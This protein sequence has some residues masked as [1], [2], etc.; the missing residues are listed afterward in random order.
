MA[1]DVE[2]LKKNKAGKTRETSDKEVPGSGYYEHPNGTSL[3][4]IED[5]LFG[6][7]QAEAAVQVGFKYVR[8][9][10]EGEVKSII[11]LQKGMEP[12]ADPVSQAK[13]DRARLDAL[14]LENFRREKRE[15]EE[16]EAQAAADEKAAK[17]SEKA[18]KKADKEIKDTVAK[19]EE[20]RPKDALDESGDVAKANAEKETQ[21]REEDKK[22][23]K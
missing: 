8:P 14:E 6:N 3:I 4:T 9:A 5:P 2:N 10:K 21:A 18:A 20:N 12:V 11:E 13:E 23:S 16:A 17:E 7:A 19:A 15:R 22:A 1:Y